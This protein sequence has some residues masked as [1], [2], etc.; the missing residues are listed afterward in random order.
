[1]SEALQTLTVLSLALLAYHYLGYLGLLWV[2]SRLIPHPV[3]TRAIEARVSLII[4]AFNEQGVIEAKLRN[5]L[6][7]DYPSLEII[8][9]TDGSDDS[10]PR[11]VEAFADKGIRCLHQPERRGKAAAMNRAAAEANGDILLFSDANAFYSSDAVARIVA[12]F[13]DANV[14]CVSG[15]KSVR[16]K[17]EDGGWT[18][19]GE[20]EGFYWKYEAAIKRLESIIAST[21][22]VVGEILAVRRTSWRP[23]PAG[24]INDDFYICLTIQK[25]GQRVV[26]ERTAVS[27][28]LPSQSLADDIKRRR[29]ITAG[30]FQALFHPGWWPWRS[31]LGLF[32]L[33]S[34]KFLRVLLPV[35]FALAL[36]GNLALLAGPAMPDLMVMTLWAQFA[37][38]ALV[39]AGVVADRL[40]KHW[41]LPSICYYVFLGNVTTARGLI[42]YFSEEQAVLWEKA[43]R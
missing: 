37:F 20:A 3:A 4:C 28:E 7:T 23:I 31:P 14:G 42:H 12:N 9:V 13:A 24:V 27:W 33:A 26:Y 11:L 35:F 16:R 6:Q 39:L 32:M 34:H 10:T 36:G 1:M 5:A 25:F 29:R 40:G 15:E 30:R 18:A 17:T 43:S 21:A 19:I 2:G 41:R 22:G 8:V 38:Y